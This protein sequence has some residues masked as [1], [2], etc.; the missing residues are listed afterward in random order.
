MFFKGLCAAFVAVMLNA[1][2]AS[3]CEAQYSTGW[4]AN[5]H[6]TATTRVGNVAR[7]M[8]VAPEGVIYTASMWDEGEGGIAIYQNG[9][10]IGSI[11]AHAE[12]QGGAITGN[13][14]SLFAALQFNAAY[15][16]GKVGRYDRTSRTRDLLITVSDTTTERLADVVTGLATSGSLLYAS[17]FPGNRVRVFTTSGVW[18]RDIGVSGPGALSVDAGGNIWVAQQ[19]MGAVIQFSPTG[20]HRNTIQLAAKAQP[21]SLYFDA[22]SGQLWI[23]DEGPDMNIK[24][25]DVSGAPYAVGTFGVQGGFLNTVTGIKGQV[26]DRRF[27][28]VTGIGRDSARNLYVLNNPWGGSWDLGRNGGTDIHA[29]DGAGVL[30]WQ[31]QSVNFEGNAAPDPATDGAIFYGGMNIY[32]GTVGGTFIANTIDPITYPSDPRIN[33]ADH[34]RGEHFAQ[35]ASVG[36]HRILVAASQNPDTFY[37][38]HFNRASG[39]I[40]IPDSTLPGA[41]FGTTAKV[42]NGFCLDS[43]GDIWAGLDKTGTI[44]HYP[45][46]GFDASGKP[47]WSAAV[48][49]P[50]PATI[51]QL[52]RIVYL[53]E[54][55]TMILTG[56]TSSTDWTAVG[57]RVEV[58]HGWLAGNRTTPNPVINLTSANPK[59]IVAAGNYLFVGYVHTVPNI[60]AFNLTTGKLDTTFV[61]SNPNSVDVGNDVDSMYGLRAYRRS[62]GEYE[63]TKDNYNDSSIVLYRWTP[64][65]S[66]GTGVSAT[67]T[68]VV[69]PFSVN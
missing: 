59:S 41:S 47:L 4:I 10:N 55:D 65:A 62:T 57:S 21:S 56:I 7:S 40:A 11:G 19:S 69:S 29:Y 43:N 38:F 34:E 25:Y 58:Y 52:T 64:P 8:W 5:T 32:S 49:V 61:N 16:S 28:R 14:T 42:R 9:R 63:I 50:I 60:D 33:L 67:K 39:Y 46:T 3:V 54:S 22:S 37:F 2:A 36:G 53:P 66:S 44:S 31:L 17:D 68:I 12:F 20:E 13:S 48:T 6:G 18:V 51:S 1:A 26:G 27:T 30:R 45:L 15:G 23:G 35:L 24:I